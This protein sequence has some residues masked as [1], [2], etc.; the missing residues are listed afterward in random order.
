MKNKIIS[1]IIASVC[2][3]SCKEDFLQRDSLTQLSQGSFWANEQDA[4]SGISATYEAYKALMVYWISYSL[5]DD[6]S[7]ISYQTWSNSFDTDAYPNSGG[8]FY[9]PWQILYGGIYRANTAIQRIPDITMNENVKKRL[10]GEAKFLRAL[11]YFKLWDMY[12]GVPIYEE[13]MNYDEAYKAR[14]SADDVYALI[15]RDCTDA[16]SVLEPN[17][18][19]GDIGRATKWAAIA[20]RGKAKLYAQKWSEAAADFKDVIDNSD[21]DLHPV[22]SQIFNY[23]W[24]VNADGTVNK[25]IL[26]DVQFM[27]QTGYGNPNNGV[28]GNP[29]TYG[30]SGGQRSIPTPILVDAYETLDGQPFSWSNYTNAKGETFD[31]NKAEDWNDEASVRKIYENRDLRMN[32]T[33]IVPWSEYIGKDN[34]KFTYKWPIVTTDATSFKSNFTAVYCWRK[35]VHEGNENTVSGNSPNNIPVIRYADVLLMYAEA[36][37]EASGPD[38]SVYDAINRVR[39]RA[40]LPPIPAGTKDEV[41]ERIRHERKVEF[42]AEGIW[43]SDIRRWKTA[44]DLCNHTVKGFIGNALRN[45]KFSERGYLFA[46]PPT[47]I[48]LN[49]KITQNPGW[50]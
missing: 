28:C 21:R 30:I 31:P 36:Q 25:E 4:V 39:N 5:L 10:I 19:K 38:Q 47:E 44:K 14:S 17:Y 15:V 33:V 3:F 40:G 23:K 42:P 12:G 18:T 43:Y 7:D 8:M 41:R 1:I 26:F 29:N 34:V 49:D 37:N 20:L 13:P 27:A 35:F 2:L 48:Q 32:Q 22:Y 46:I 50:E 45:R 9:N 24:E 11:Y 16:I 6:F